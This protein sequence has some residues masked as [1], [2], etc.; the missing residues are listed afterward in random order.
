VETFF[1]RERPTARREMAGFARYG[2]KIR[3]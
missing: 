1:L 3:R 2:R